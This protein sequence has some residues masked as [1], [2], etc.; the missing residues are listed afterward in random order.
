MT[1]KKEAT[2]PPSDESNR[3]VDRC[4]I[5]YANGDKLECELKSGRPEG[6]G[7]MTFAGG[8]HVLECDGLKD[9]KANGKGVLIAS[10]T[11]SSQA[12]S[13][14]LRFGELSSWI[15]SHGSILTTGTI[16]HRTC[17]TGHVLFNRLNPLLY[18]LLWSLSSVQAESV[19][20]DRVNC[21][22]CLKMLGMHFSIVLGASTIICMAPSRGGDLII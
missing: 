15:R 3:A 9:G 11:L 16:N 10:W 20:V 12:A 4:T 6:K 18:N 22:G 13:R 14:T 8:H 19:S 7:V 2:A 17:P 1:E 21:G 5:D